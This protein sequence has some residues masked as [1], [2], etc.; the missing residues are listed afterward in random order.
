MQGFDLLTLVM[1]VLYCHISPFYNL[2]K[3][4][5]VFIQLSLFQ[6]SH[7]GITPT[8]KRVEREETEELKRNIERRILSPRT[9]IL[10]GK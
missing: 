8:F 5:I 3:V 6:S 9:E 2:V 10:S 7:I 1:A 4:D